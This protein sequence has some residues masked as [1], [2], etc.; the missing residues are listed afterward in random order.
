[1]SIM[2]VSPILIAAWTSL[3]S[4]L[5]NFPASVKCMQTITTLLGS[6]VHATRDCR[7]S[8]V[9]GHL[10]KHLQGMAK[11]FGEFCY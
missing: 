7:A 2:Q 4:Y 1:M 9:I 6:Q 3:V 8:I 5:S 11:R 10:S